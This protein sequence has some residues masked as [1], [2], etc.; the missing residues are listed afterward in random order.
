MKMSVKEFSIFSGVSV[1][2]LHYYDEINLLKPDFVD[3]ENGYRYYGDKATERMLEILFLKDLDFPLKEIADILSSPDYNKKEAF[4]KQRKLLTL[5]KERLEGLI[6]ALES[7]EKGQTLMR[8]FDNTEFDKAKAQYADEVKA[9]WGNTE[10][11]K[12][13]EEKTSKMSGA[14]KQ[15]ALDGMEFIMSE[16]GEAMK[17][18]FI[19]ESEA[20]QGL[21]KKLQQF[22]T[23]NFYTCTKEILAGLGEMYVLDER[24]RKNIDKNGEGTAEFIR[25][26]LRIYCKS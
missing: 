14:E 25:A 11:Y 18:G 3:I 9:R 10:A 22:I 24:F 4:R 26:A 1:R 2:T 12:E 15:S 8:K 19:P 21:C 13:S 16:F 6:Y 23:D 7:A 20:A 17:K 5:K